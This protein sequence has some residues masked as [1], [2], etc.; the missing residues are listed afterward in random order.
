MEILINQLDHRLSRE[1]SQ[2]LRE[3]VLD[4]PGQTMLSPSDLPKLI[5]RPP[6]SDD[7]TEAPIDSVSLNPGNKGQS[8]GGAG[9]GVEWATFIYY[10]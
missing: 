7:L 1:K 8:C 2:G 10:L 3:R 9:D 6:G 5:G 4:G